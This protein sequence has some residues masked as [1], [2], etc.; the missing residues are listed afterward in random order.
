MPPGRCEERLNDQLPMPDLRNGSERKRKRTEFAISEIAH[1][2]TYTIVRDGTDY[3]TLYKEQCQ[4]Q[5][6]EPLQ[7]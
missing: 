5:G 1:G 6:E 2:M 7:R 3:T 4:S